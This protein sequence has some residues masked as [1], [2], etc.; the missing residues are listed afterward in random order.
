MPSFTLAPDL[1]LACPK[2]SFVAFPNVAACHWLVKL[3]NVALMPQPAI[4]VEEFDNYEDLDIYRPLED[5]GDT[6]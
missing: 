1:Y 4:R 5:T 6:E 2:E 3:P